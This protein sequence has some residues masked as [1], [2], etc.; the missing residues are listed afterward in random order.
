[1]TTQE[2]KQLVK[3]AIIRAVPSVMDLVFGCEVKIGDF[4]RTVFQVFYDE[5]ENVSN[6]LTE[7]SSIGMLQY[8]SP[9][10]FEIIGRPIQLQ[11]V[12]VAIDKAKPLMELCVR[13]TGTFIDPERISIGIHWDL[14]QDFDHQSEETIDFLYELWK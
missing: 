4:K 13:Q 1:M 5:D 3:E 7:S 14:S 2:K 10:A 8:T 6:I 11:D 9:G 12:L